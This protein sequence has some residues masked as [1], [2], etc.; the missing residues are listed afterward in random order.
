MVRTPKW[1]KKR[2]PWFSTYG[3]G[4]GRYGKKTFKQETKIADFE[5]H[6]KIIDNN[7][8]LKSFY[9]QKLVEVNASGEK[10]ISAQ[11]TAV[12]LTKQFADEKK[13]SWRLQK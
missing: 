13:I 4:G 10:G 12:A 1:K 8:A 6:K 11:E 5:L 2:P 3:K 7:P 9:L